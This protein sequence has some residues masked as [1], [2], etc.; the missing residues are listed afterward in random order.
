[1]RNA[2]QILVEKL[3][4]K[5]DRMEDIGVNGKRILKWILMAWGGN[6]SQLVQDRV[7]W[8]AL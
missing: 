7:Q 1:M 6:K 8:R 2:Y 5:R 3:E 4:E